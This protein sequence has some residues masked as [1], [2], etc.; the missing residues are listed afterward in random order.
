[1]LVLNHIVDAIKLKTNNEQNT[2]ICTFSQVAHKKKL[3]LNFFVKLTHNLKID[4][5]LN[6]EWFEII[7]I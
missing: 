5:R 1:M 3:N 6:W 4:A 7:V 2:Q